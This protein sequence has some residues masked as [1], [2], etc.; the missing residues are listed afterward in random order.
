MGSGNNVFA[1]QHP[2]R[3]HPCLSIV[4]EALTTI[5]KVLLSK[6]AFCR[7]SNTTHGP[8]D[9]IALAADP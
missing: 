9:E 3:V 5:Y 8:S 7:V 1:T 6:G 4:S 2:A